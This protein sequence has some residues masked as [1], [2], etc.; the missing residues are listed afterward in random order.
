MIDGAN[1][2]LLSGAQKARIIY[3]QAR[4]EL[5]DRLWR[6]A[7][8]ADVEEPDAPRG[9]RGLPMSLD[10]LLALLEEHKA[11]P[12]T[13]TASPM[14][15]TDP[16]PTAVGPQ[17]PLLPVSGDADGA[18]QTRGNLAKQ[19]AAQGYGPNAGY[20]VILK[21]AAR[22]TGV[23]TAALATIV[24]AEAAKGTD[25][26][27]LPYSRN[28]RSSAA[29]LG[30][31]LSGTWRDEADRQ[32]TWLHGVAQQQGWL[33]AQGKVKQEHRGALLALRYDPEASIQATADYVHANLDALRRAGIAIGEDAQ[34]IARAAYLGHHL[35][36]GDAVRFL[37]GG[38]D[39][40]RAR[41]L[42]K[43]QIGNASASRRIAASGDA[44]MA[45]RAWLMDYIGKNIRPERFTA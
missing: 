26:R 37:S 8:G 9:A 43:A 33:D 35:G 21:A 27:W 18:G 22:R 20:A 45:H 30:Q 3:A 2:A 29:G 6:A 19:S 25:G 23:P 1:P 32:G 42:L 4:N 28:P 15:A 17:A 14:A 40:S 44:S 10:S 12:E 7:L 24:H 13:S 34:A 39:P 5:T 36:R 11:P 41:T 38:I 16:A 31:F